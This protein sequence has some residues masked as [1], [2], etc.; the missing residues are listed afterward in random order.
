M[1]GQGYGD[2]NFEIPDSS[3]ITGIQV[4]TVGYSRE[5]LLVIDLIQVNV[6]YF[7]IPGIDSNEPN[8]NWVTMYPNPARDKTTLFFHENNS[9]GNI[10]MDL[11]SLQGQ[12]VLHQPV[13]T[14]KFDMDLKLLQ[15]GIYTLVISDGE[16]IAVLKLIKIPSD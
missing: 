4:K 16:R 3:V 14:D 10:F 7:V 13:H 8:G 1:R 11:F 6:N 2:F 12:N 9:P 5:W 15:A